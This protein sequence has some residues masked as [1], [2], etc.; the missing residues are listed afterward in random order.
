MTTTGHR[1]ATAK[2]RGGGATAGVQQGGG[3]PTK[4]GGAP[5]R[6]RQGGGH[7]GAMPPRPCL[8][9][10]ALAVATRCPACTRTHGRPYHHGERVEHA[11]LIREWVDQHGWTCPGAPDLGHPPHRVQPGALTADHVIEVAHGG[12]RA[13]GPKRILCRSANSSRGGRM[14]T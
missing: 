6:R 12:Q 13:G 11:Q 8:T 14:R 9:C 2:G 1:G 7:T 4:A 3:A 10:G 5:T